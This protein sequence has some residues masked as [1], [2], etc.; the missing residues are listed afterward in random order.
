MPSIPRD[1]SSAKVAINLDS[2]INVHGSIDHAIM[3][4]DKD[5]GGI[6]IINR[7]A[8]RTALW[9]VDLVVVPIVGMYCTSHD[10]A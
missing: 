9:K 5:D 2:N 7:Q 8:E 6:V 1:D 3:D 10:Y 4:V